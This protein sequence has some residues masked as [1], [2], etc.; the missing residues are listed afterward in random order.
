MRELVIG[1]VIPFSG[2]S[3]TAMIRYNPHGVDD[4]NAVWWRYPI[5]RG[6]R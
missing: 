3:E 5:N 6:I 2:G 4:D 1:G